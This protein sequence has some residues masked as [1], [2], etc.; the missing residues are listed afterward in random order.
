[1]VTRVSVRKP[2]WTASIALAPPMEWPM[3]AC[4][5]GSSEA[6]SSMARANSTTFAS[7]PGERPWAGP[8]RATTE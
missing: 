1:M 6:A 7:L 5:G 8:S 2:N 4:R 3:T